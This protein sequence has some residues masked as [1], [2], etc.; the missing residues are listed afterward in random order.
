MELLDPLNQPGIE[1]PD[2]IPGLLHRVDRQMVF[3]LDLPDLLFVGL[4]DRLE[5][6]GFVV[7]LGLEL[8]DDLL[9]AGQVPLQDGDLFVLELEQLTLG[10]ELELHVVDCQ[11]ALVLLV[12]GFLAGGVAAGPLAA[13]VQVL[14]P[15][16]LRLALGGVPGPRLAL[17]QGLADRLPQGV[18]LLP[19]G[20]L[21]RK[22]VFEQVLPLYCR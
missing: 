9:A 2:L 18:Q 15:E 13:R 22:P 1:G 10:L 11:Q 3:L 19:E 7:G 4:L 12:L 8:G 5:Q 17:A 21:G 14:E 6:A 16:A 20:S